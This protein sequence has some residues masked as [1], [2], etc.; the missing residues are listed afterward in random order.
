MVLIHGGDIESYRLEYGRLPLDFSANCNPLG[1]PA[2]VKRAIRDAAAHADAYP[3][4]LCRKLCALIA[5]KTGTLPERVLCGNGAADL[6]YRAALACKPK[7]ALVP[8]PSFAEY[9][10]A[11][12]TV[13]CE[14]IRH[15]LRAEEDF[16]L[17]SDILPA[18][19][20]DIDMLFLC[21][22]NNPTGLVIDPSLLRQILETCEREGILLIVDECFNGFLEEPEI[23]TL[24]HCLSEYK[25]LLVIDAF[26][27]L[28][29]MAGVRLGYCLSGNEK[30]L[31]K[32]RRAGQPWAVSSLAQA[33]GIAALQEH[34]YIL[35]TRV[36]VRKERTFLLKELQS[37]GIKAY[38]GEA[39]FIFFHTEIPHLA[40]QMRKA[41]ILIRDC[42]NYAGLSDGYY[43]IAVRKHDENLRLLQALRKAAGKYS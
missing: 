20:P 43:R 1:V 6:I 7:R 5:D 21:N 9:E 30:L 23:H 25:N 10:L 38:V 37:L 15:P 41:G 19:K 36:L 31:E 11:L 34:N 4:P 2:G 18:L 14:I 13:D 42:S 28:Y 24:R 22:P 35:R 12:R 40:E 16:A 17:A 27:K 8:A 29:G 32:M 3:D 39:N 26:T 33:A